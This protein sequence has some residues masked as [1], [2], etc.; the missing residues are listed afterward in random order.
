MKTLE[1][2]QT[3]AEVLEWLEDM[4][5]PAPGNSCRYEDIAEIKEALGQAA[6]IGATLALKCAAGCV[7]DFGVE[8]QLD[9]GLDRGVQDIF[10]ARERVKALDAAATVKKG[11]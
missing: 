3:I 5:Y 11:M 10:R 1:T 2:C 8:K 7:D 6:L 9:N 4:E